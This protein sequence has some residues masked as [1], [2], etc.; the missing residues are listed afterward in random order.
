VA[1][2]YCWIL[3]DVEQPT[4][5]GSRSLMVPDRTK[6]WVP[7]ASSFELRVLG[8][9]SRHILKGMQR[10]EVETNNRD[11][12]TTAFADGKNETVVMVN[13]GAAALNVAVAGA[14]KPWTEMERTSIEEPNTVSEVPAE[15]VVAPGQIVV[16]S[17]VAAE[18]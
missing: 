12:L 6:G 1:L 4:F 8:A 17:N 15:V 10:I 13:R 18:R 11:L 16:L 5:G 2:I 14:P 7:V 9:F 3:L